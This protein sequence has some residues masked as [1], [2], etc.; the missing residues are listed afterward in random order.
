[1]F[2][3][4]LFFF[5]LFFCLGIALASTIKISFAIV[6]FTALILLMLG[7]LTSG[8]ELRSGIFISSLFF[9]LGAVSLR[10][11]QTLPSCHI[12]NYTSYKG[13]RLYTIRG[14]IDNQPTHKDNALVF[15]FQSRQIQVDNLG[16]NCCGPVLVYASV[17]QDLQYGEELL[18][19][20]R[21]TRPRGFGNAKGSSYRQYLYNQGI[22]ALMRVRKATGIIRLNKR[23]GPAVQQL[24]LRLKNQIEGIIFQRLSPLAAS[25]LEAMV[26]GEKRNI[27]AFAYNSMIKSGTVHILVVSGFNVGLVF[28][29]IILFLRLLHFPRRVRIGLAIPLLV[30]YCLVTGASNPVLRATVMSIL[31]LCSYLFKREPDIYNAC[32]L[33]G[34][35]IL[36]INPKQLFDIGFQ[37]SFVSVFSIVYLYP[38]LKA[39]LRIEG[40]KPKPIQLLISSCLVSLSAWLGTAGLIAGNFKIFSPVTVLANIFIVPLATL[41]TLSGF[42]LIAVSLITPA[43]AQSFAS[44]TELLVIL[45]L[46]I[47]ALLIKLPGAYFYLS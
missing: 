19:T 22:Y 13:N 17:R 23:A 46:Q 12:R 29:S 32:A 27:P 34:F 1:M 7:F 16:H 35:F 2:R 28:L 33:A 30:L 42:S 41:I 3:H 36:G 39:W 47:N 11:A 15:I 18:I 8:D 43:L 21:L 40:L 24:A 45:L 44:T 37:L 20:G 4:P 38:K 6:Y 5:L 31:F 25:I 14:F 10:N 26:L 9:L